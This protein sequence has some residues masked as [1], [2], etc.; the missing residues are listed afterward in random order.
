MSCRMIDLITGTESQSDWVY[1]T[2]IFG[3]RVPKEVAAILKEG[4]EKMKKSGEITDKNKWQI[5][6]YLFADFLGK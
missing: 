1:I 5:L 6:E 3:A 4:I 2:D